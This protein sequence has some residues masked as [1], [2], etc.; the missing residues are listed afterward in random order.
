MN[1]SL[2]ILRHLQHIRVRYIN[3]NIKLIIYN[4]YLY[5]IYIYKTYI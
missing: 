5:I 1:Y 4:I 3:N 2:K